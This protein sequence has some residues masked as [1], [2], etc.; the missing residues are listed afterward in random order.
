MDMFK[1]NGYRVINV[2]RLISNPH[3]SDFRSQADSDLSIPDEYEAGE[4]VKTDL[5][6]FKEEAT[7]K[8]REGK[9]GTVIYKF[10][11]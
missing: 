10:S 4:V 8:M 7:F 1:D 9:E 5:H 2:K 6:S 3:T 11:N